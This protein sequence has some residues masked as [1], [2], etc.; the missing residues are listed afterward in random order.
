[1]GRYRSRSRSY[2]PRRSRS[3]SP[4]RRKRYDDPHD[5]SRGS[6]SSYRDHRSS[7]PSGLLVRNI[8][9]DARSDGYVWLESIS[10][11]EKIV[12]VAGLL[13]WQIYGRKLP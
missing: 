6:R 9:L 2:S 10:N 3:R 4:P 1:M 5:R 13:Q 12:L 8:S 7:G 11:F